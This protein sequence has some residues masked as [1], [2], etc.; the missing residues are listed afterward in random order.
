[1]RAEWF[2]TT[3][4][5]PPRS[6]NTALGHRRDD[7]VVIRTG[8]IRRRRDAADAGTGV[9]RQSQ[10]SWYYDFP[11]C[12]STACLTTT[13]GRAGGAANARLADTCLSF[14]LLDFVRPHFETTR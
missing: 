8:E 12:R 3:T 5:L 11:V 10:I 1:M 9:A 7:R 14:Q 13:S 4:A 6:K 2:T